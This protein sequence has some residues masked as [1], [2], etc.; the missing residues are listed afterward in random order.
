MVVTIKFTEPSASTMVVYARK[1]EYR[2]KDET[3]QITTVWKS[4]LNFRPDDLRSLVV[5]DGISVPDD[6]LR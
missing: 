2:G 5:R 4:I 6:A 1:V 3:I